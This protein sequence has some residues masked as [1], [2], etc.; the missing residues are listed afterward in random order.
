MKKLLLFISF[1]TIGPFVKAQD[2]AT[3]FWA[4]NVNTTT[5]V[6]TSGGVISSNQT[7]TES[8][9]IRDYG[10]TET[11]QRVY[12]SGSGLGYWPNETTEN[13]DRYCE[14]T[15]TPRSGLSFQLTQMQFFLGNSGGSN[16]VRASIYYSTD[17]FAT[18]TRIDSNM[19]LPSAALKEF[20]YEISDS[21]IT[22]ENQQPITVRV[23]PWLQGGVASGKYFNITKVKFSGV[24]LGELI[25]ELPEV[26]SDKIHT[27]STQTAWFNGNVANDGGVT[28]DSVGLVLSTEPNPDTTDRVI[29]APSQVGSFSLLMEGLI[30]DQTYYVKAFAVNKAGVSFGNELTFTTLE[31]LSIPGV[32][33]V[34][35]SDLRPTG[36]IA[37][38]DVFFDGGLTVSLTG[39]CFS[40]QSSPTIID[41]VVE[42]G[43]GTGD[44]SA[45]LAN[46]I[47]QK[48]YYVRAFAQNSEG[49]GY[50]DEI[51]FTT[52]QPE[53]DMNIVVDIAGNGDYTTLQ[54][55][56]NNIPYNYMGNI[57]VLVKKG[58]Y[59]EKVLLEKGKINVRLKGEYR[60][61]TIIRWDDYSG[62]IVDGVTLGT[63]TS[64]TIAIDADDFIAQN[65]TFQNTYNGSQ[66]VALRVKGDR[67]IFQQCRFLGYQDTYYTWGVGR[68][69]H[70]DCYIEGTVDFIFG[71]SVAVFQ[72]CTI[73]S[74]RNSPVTAAA[75]PQN[76]KFG[77]V[78]KNCKL[79]ADAGISGATLGRPW[80]E[81]AQTVFIETE[82]GKH[83]S[84]AGWLE[85]SGTNNHLTAYYAEYNCSGDGYKPESRVSWSHQLTDE[86]AALYTLENIFSK[87]TA[88]PAYYYDWVP[89]FEP[90]TSV[91]DK[92]LEETTVLECYPN[93]FTSQIYIKV[94]GTETS[95]VNLEIYSINGT[96]VKQIHGKNINQ[97]QP[98][99]EINTAELE[100]GIYLCKTTINGLA[101]IQK[102]IVK[103]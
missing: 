71:S 96:L 20:V 13:L 81:Y 90:V 55:A 37:K 24:T 9:I 44:F 34:A 72:N 56:F 75:T 22:V 40:G 19:V 80:K 30:P 6:I 2:T 54:D 83:I 98:L 74:L 41:Q 31:K 45:Y 63:S 100:Q 50:G 1:L 64:Y 89:E 62:K 3:V 12:A 32:T 70:E 8:Y 42:A 49:I 82:E 102:I 26:S 39:F 84:P 47:S 11:S 18:A 53:P 76:Y 67:M 103:E 77:Y 14:F 5:S 69:Y 73:K 52:P 15:V 92:K 85:W 36:A 99:I 43:E 93:P 38:G 95:T 7:A 58:I 21:N 23:F 68:V 91:Y 78:F 94:H 27:I 35:V 28:L 57:N 17:G 48:T 29:L 66:A 87:E 33:T 65:I 4:L 79:I 25:P 59:N 86:E 60:D 16:N 46:L 51:S 97:N 10:G 101:S 88:S 61:S